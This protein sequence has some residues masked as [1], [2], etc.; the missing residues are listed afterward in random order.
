MTPRALPRRARAEWREPGREK[1]SRPA[2]G[3]GAHPRRS[4]RCHLLR[5]A[6]GLE[7]LPQRP[8]KCPFA[9]EAQQLGGGRVAVGH[10][11]AFVGDDHRRADVLEDRRFEGVLHG[12]RGFAGI[13]PG[14]TN[15]LRPRSTR[16]NPALAALP[17][18]SA[19]I[20]C[21]LSSAP[22]RRVRLPRR[23][24]LRASQAPRDPRSGCA[25]ACRSWIGV[26][27]AGGSRFARALTRWQREI[28]CRSQAVRGTG[29]RC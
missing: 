12:R 24:G 19:W 21:S 27:R 3:K 11:E 9:E 4:R 2:G 23:R 20:A 22:R 14:H 26:S 25:T 15:K 28:S 16:V 6:L 5:H 8:A 7:Q 1:C 13:A 29:P 18:L 17:P 10:P